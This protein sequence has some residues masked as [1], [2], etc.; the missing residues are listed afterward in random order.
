MVVKC[1]KDDNFAKYHTPRYHC[2]IEM[3]FI[4]RLDVKLWQSVERKM[5]VK[6]KRS[7]CVVVKCIKDNYFAKYH[8]PRYHCC[9]E[10]W[11]I[12][13]LDVKLW[14]SVERKMKVKGKR[15]W[16]VVVKCIKDNYFARFQT[17]SY[18]CCRE[19]YLISGL[20]INFDKVSG[21]W[22]EGQGHRVKVPAWRVCQG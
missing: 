3:W 5:K 7:W 9:I 17:H 14:Q 4:S 6:G 20:D 2:C 19:M 13:R 15:S 1:I 21:A 16:C 12:S 10:M 8:T 22:N 18:Q 11:F